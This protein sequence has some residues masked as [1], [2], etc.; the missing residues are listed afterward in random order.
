MSLELKVAVRTVLMLAGWIGILF[1]PAGTWNFWQGWAF[2]AALFFPV[3]IAFVY[4]LRYDRPLMERRM[5][6]REALKEQQ[7]LMRLFVLLM[8]A[9][10][11]L[12]GF[13]H[14]MGWSRRWV[15]EVRVWLTVL[16][17]VMV[18]GGLVFAFWV[19]KVNSYAGRTIEVVKGQSVISTGPYGLVRHPMYFGS[20][21]L[22]LSAPL[23]LGSWVALPVFALS[24]PIFAMRLLNE[25]KVLRAGL[26]GYADYCQKIRYHLI[27]LIW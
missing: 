16:A 26:T 3:M 8:L 5:K 23:A 12:P 20:L 10:F 11:S 21:M 25:E 19:M 4:F 1:L 13:D 7:L 14:R 9:A 27:P 22:L 17:L 15:G 2:L 18:V 24:I 6:N